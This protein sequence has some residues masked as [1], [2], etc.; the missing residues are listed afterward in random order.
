MSTCSKILS[1]KN[2]T[3]NLYTV[4]T[5][6]VTR[7]AKKGLMAFPIA[8]TWEPIPSIV[9]KVATTAKLGQGIPLT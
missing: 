8:C 2:S 1:S 9:I 6:Y 5:V 7:S 4:A 3:Q